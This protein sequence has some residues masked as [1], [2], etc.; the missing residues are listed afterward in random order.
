MTS[1]EQN[2]PFVSLES[3]VGRNFDIRPLRPNIDAESINE[4]PHRHSFQ[5]LLWVK[6]GSGRHRIDDDTLE[7]HAQTFYLITKGQIHYFIEGVDLE[8]YILR[9]SDDFLPNDITTSGWDYRMTLFSHFSLNQMLSPEQNDIE[10]FQLIMDNMWREIRTDN[11][12]K[13]HVLQHLLSILIILLER[14]R[15]KNPVIES[16]QDPN[17]EVFQSFITALEDDFRREHS[18]NYYAQQI[19]M[20]PRQLSDIVKICTGKTAKTLILERVILEAKR[21][22]Q[23]TN[24]SIKEIA[25]ALG[26]KDS[27]YFSKVFKQMT[28]VSPNQY[29]VSL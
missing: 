13:D 8:G 12:G 7:I 22:L 16:T 18:V 28:G 3:E 6:S 23:H 9:F 25:F 10:T 5:E 27:S 21:H 26:F 19:H 15:K 24:A 2:I 4:V 17:L 11:F 1:I 20:T 29:D 14:S